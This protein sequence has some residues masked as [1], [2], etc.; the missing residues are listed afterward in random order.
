MVRY[1]YY[2]G[3]VDNVSNDN[4]SIFRNMGNL[5]NKGYYIKTSNISNMGYLINKC[6]IS[7]E[8]NFSYRGNFSYKSSN[9]NEKES[10][11]VLLG[12]AGNSGNIGNLAKMTSHHL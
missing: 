8:I 12:N 11:F 4:E 2:V 9:K 6:N 3:N 10:A 1:G 7:N 5:I